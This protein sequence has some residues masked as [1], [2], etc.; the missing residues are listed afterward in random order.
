M[1]HLRFLVVIIIIIV[2]VIVLV[3]VLITIIKPVA[4]LWCAVPLMVLA[5]MSFLVVIIIKI[6]I[7]IILVLVILILITIIKPVATLCSSTYG[8]SQHEQDQG[9]PAQSHLGHLQ[10]SNHS[11]VCNVILKHVI[12]KSVFFHLSM[13][14]IQLCTR[15]TAQSETDLTDRLLWKLAPPIAVTTG[16]LTKASAT[17]VHWW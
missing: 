8:F 7:I 5:N 4:T 10:S 9:C 14:V 6:I 3:L 15:L 17:S 13:L 2:I 11:L 12:K 16:I 1:L